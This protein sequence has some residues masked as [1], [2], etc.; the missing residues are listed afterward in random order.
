MVK[1]MENKTEQVGDVR[2]VAKKKTIVEKATSLLESMWPH[3]YYN[4]IVMILFVL[5]VFW[6]GAYLLVVALAIKLLFGV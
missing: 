3:L 1:T 6:W 5:G 2:N 4:V